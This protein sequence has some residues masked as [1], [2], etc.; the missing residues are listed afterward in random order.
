MGKQSE[1]PDQGKKLSWQRIL[2]GI[3]FIAFVWLIVSRINQVQKLAQTLE[4]GQWQWVL[5]AALLQVIYYLAFVGTYQAAFYTLGIRR[6]L[7]ELVPVTL[8]SLFVNVVTPTASAAGA[9]LFVDDAARAGHSPARATTATLLQLVADYTAFLMVLVVGITVLFIKH[10]LQVYEILSA[11]VLLL[12]TGVLAGVLLL[13]VWR[14]QMVAR[15]LRWL[16]ALINRVGSWFRHP[17]LLDADWAYT[18]TAE[19]TSASQAVLE[20]P[21]RLAILLGITLLAYA[22]DLISLYALFMAFGQP[23]GFGP[24]VAG[25]SMGILFWIVSPIPQGIGLVEGIMTLT[26]TSL[27]VPSETA[28]IVSLAFR[29]L[30]FWLPLLLGFALIRRTRTFGGHERSLAENWSVHLAALLAA[31]MGIVN[32]LSAVT[33]SLADRLEKLEHFIPLVVR[34]GGHLTAALAGFAL[35]ALSVGLW[36]R[37]RTAWTITILVLVLSSFGHLLKGLDYEEA[38]LG[39]A[40]ALWMLTQRA[41]FYARSDP[42]SLRQGLWA[43]AVSMGFTLLYGVTGFYLLDKHFS[44]NFGLGAAIRQTVVMFV[45]FY[46]P[47]LQPVPVTRFGHFF[48]GSIYVVGFATF[49]YALIM[50][51]RPVL[52]HQIASPHERASAQEIVK[53]YGR[54]SL[55]RMAL[56]DD[57]AYYFSP[58]GSVIAYTASNG[59]AVAL[60]DPIGPPSDAQ[61]AINGF[62]AFCAKND[63]VPAFYQTQPDCLECYYSSGFKSLN[64]GSEA[65]VELAKFSI[66]GGS[67]KGLRSAYHRL[68]KL[69]FRAVILF[70]PH[71]PALLSDMRAIS[72]AWLSIKRG[73]E[74]HF[75]LGWFD[76]QY[77][78]STPVIV[79]YNPEDRLIAFA[80]VVP[81]YQRSEV[82]ID[83]MRY[84]SGEHG[85]MDFMFVSLFEWARS[86]GYAQFNLGLST[87]SGVGENPEDPNIERALHFTYEHIRHFYNFKGLHEFKSKFHPIWSPRYL[88]YPNAAAL[89]PILLAMNAASRGGDIFSNYRFSLKKKLAVR[90]RNLDRRNQVKVL[91]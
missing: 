85:I 74:K 82:S 63:W 38:I 60:G 91:L 55:A 21:A 30:T 3:L 20:Y 84:L 32:V 36:R 81:E 8:G 27:G 52:M 73:T 90:L 6:K 51:L 69:G 89:P 47:G 71:N 25:F 43:V 5:A 53:H 50:L 2:L 28:T 1:I 23:V 10:D 29:G 18:N 44:V 80:N 77:L 65:I 22:I 34:Q 56:F 17:D 64:I 33:P 41:H 35:L 54:T 48:A 76:E 16:Q 4:Q 24:L 86:Q 45:A 37:K 79:V 40:L 49:L 67:N 7:F 75:S 83:L 59:A 68:I 62:K 11:L 57:K 15:L 13:G 31:A 72:D 14:P 58:G 9:A 61:K 66:T 12:L 42:P 70:P 39:F 19:F 88:I 26:Y 78:Q 46:N 87:L